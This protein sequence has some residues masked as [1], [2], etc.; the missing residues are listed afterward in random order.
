MTLIK[1]GSFK[2]NHFYA[3][4]NDDEDVAIEAIK[5]DSSQISLIDDALRFNTNVAKVSISLSPASRVMFDLDIIHQKEVFLVLIENDLPHHT[6]AHLATAPLHLRDDVDVMQKAFKIH[7]PA[8]RFALKNALMHVIESEPMCLFHVDGVFTDD[9]EILLKACGLNGNALFY[10]SE[11]LKD[12]DELVKVAMTQ[13]GKALRHASLRLK[14]DPITCRVALLQNP[15]SFEFCDTVLKNDLDFIDFAIA[16]NGLNIRFLRPQ[17]RSDIA[18]IKKA[19]RSEP[20]AL[21]YA[22]KE[23]ALEIVKE[24]GMLLRYVYLNMML[25]FSNNIAHAAVKQN[26]LALQLIPFFMTLANVDHI[27]QSAILQNGLALEFAPDRFKDNFKYVM[28]AKE[29][30]PLSLIYA[31]DRLKV[32]LKFLKSLSVLLKRDSESEKA[33]L[34]KIHLVTRIMQLNEF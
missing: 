16:C 30:N 27:V 9:K 19:M 29:S 33:R 26:G 1:F 15:F 11:R 3:R 28:I 8:L 14:Q 31:S 7:P 20:K 34:E 5:K 22:T 32:Q 24:N 6:V 10:A 23:T 18:M 12:D 13:N 2:L 21:W 25:D 17:F 4:F